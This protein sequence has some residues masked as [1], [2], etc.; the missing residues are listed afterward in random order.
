MD[1][2]IRSKEVKKNGR[3]QSFG[4]PI[5]ILGQNF[6]HLTIALTPL[7]HF[8]FLENSDSWPEEHD[9]ETEPLTL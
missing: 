7:S 4:I 8:F 2:Y 6:H 3:F 9:S 5:P 1:K